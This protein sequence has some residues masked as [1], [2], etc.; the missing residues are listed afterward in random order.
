MI[1]IKLTY[2]RWAVLWIDMKMNRIYFIISIWFLTYINRFGM[3][4][5]SIYP[6]DKNPSD[7]IGKGV[8]STKLSLAF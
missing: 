8:N 5:R 2:S 3:G 6:L 7:G 4:L 1:I